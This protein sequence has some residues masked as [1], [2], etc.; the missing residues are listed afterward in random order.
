ME[1]GIPAPDFAGVMPAEEFQPTW[2]EEPGSG[3]KIRILLADDHAVMRDGL[4]M[5]V[6][7]EPDMEVV[8]QA[9]DGA[10]AVE[11]ARTLRP[12]VILMDQSMPRLTGVEATRVI[13][14]ELPQVK[15]IGLSMFEESEHA[16]TML[17]AGAVAYLPKSGPSGNI[18][19]AIRA[20]LKTEPS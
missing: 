6:N 9:A 17:A 1:Q 15:V 8:G 3:A 12:D 20:S 5:L 4:V 18:L 16:R 2:I 7:T 13:T 10:A 14:A 11:L 19:A